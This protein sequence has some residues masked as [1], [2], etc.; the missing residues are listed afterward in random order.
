MAPGPIAQA[1]RA[2]AAA[3][4]RSARGLGFDAP[5][6]RVTFSP[7]EGRLVSPYPQALGIAPERLAEGLPL[8]PELERCTPS[9]RWLAFELSRDWWRRA[10]RRPGDFSP[11]ALPPLPPVPDF[12]A[13]IIPFAWALNA[14]LGTPKPETAA[15]LDRG[16]P[17]VLI[18]LAR[19]RAGAG[20]AVR[21]DR[22]LA[23]LALAA[24]EEAR[25]RALAWDL[26]KLARAYLRA[27][28][29]GALVRRA[30]E[31]GLAALGGGRAPERSD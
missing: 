26:V 28:G 23:A 27:P 29:E 13:R 11:L 1:A 6:A 10:R 22:V 24:L 31:R 4:E 16:N 2:A 15:R 8:P 3:L 25:P 18:Q 17:A 7:E 14:L 5:P 9:G 30:L 19:Q 12:P 20:A 21:E